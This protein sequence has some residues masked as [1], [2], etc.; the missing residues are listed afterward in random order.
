[1][2]DRSPTGA[3][4]EADA[5]ILDTSHR[6]LRQVVEGLE[7]NDFLRPT[8]CRGWVVGDLLF[9]MLL[10]AQ[11]ALVAF[12]TPANGPPDVDFVSY[13]RSFSADDEGAVAHARFVRINAAAHSSPSSL[14]GRWMETSAAAARVA[15][16]AP[17]DRHV[18]TQGH[19]LAVPDFIA[20]LV[21]EAAIH[22]LD[23]VVDL[24][25]ARGPDE[26]P[27]KLVRRTLEGLLGEPAGIGWDDA[28]FAL[29]ATGRE[30]LSATELSAL[31]E[32]ADRFPA[33][34]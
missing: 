2:D 3:A 16:A 26:G 28:T 18:S 34:S 24:P 4:A 25:H 32:R 22:H 33:F 17:S 21:V 13:W 12:A 6:G 31:G 10:D 9:H 29:K 1:M 30:P 14:A 5:E 8:R 15:R 11:R 20:T 27:L 7:E 23:L 19:V